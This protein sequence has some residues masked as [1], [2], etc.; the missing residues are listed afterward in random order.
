[1]LLPVGNHGGDGDC[2]A[3]QLAAEIEELSLGSTGGL[4]DRL[5][6]LPDDI[7]HSIL[8]RLPSTPAAARTCVLSRRWR[9]IWAQLPEIRFPFPSNPAVVG[10]ALA[11]S[12]AGP[13][14]RL[15]HVA[16]RDDTGAN[17]WLRTAASRL[18]AGGELYFYKRTPG[19]EK[20]QAEALS[21]QCRN[22]ELPCF[23]TAAKVWL[24]LGFVDLE[25]PPTGVFARLTELR[26]EHVNLERGFQLGDMVS[27]PRCPALRELCIARAWGVVSLCIISQ[28]LER[29]ELDILHGLEELTVVA[30]ML[31]ALNVHACFAWRKPVAAIYAS[32]LEVL[33]WSDAFDPS[34]VLFGEVEN[35]QQLTT[36]DIHVYGRFDYALL[37]DYVMLLQHF[38]TVSCLD[39]KLNYQRD[40]SQYEYLMGIITKLPN[41]KILSLWLH[42]KGH[43]IGPSVFHLLSKCPGIRELKLT[44]LDNLQVDT[45]CTSVCACG[46]QQNWSTSYTLDV[47]DEVEIRN[48]RGLEHDFAFVD[49]LFGVSTAI[50]KMTI[51]LHHLASPSEELFSLGNL[52]TCFEINYNT[53]EVSYAPPDSLFP[54][55]PDDCCE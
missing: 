45:P 16:C 17:A 7:L 38:P 15:L 40:L 6:A 36:F 21:W 28:T 9:G 22:F 54:K 13:A 30:P 48:F 12:A 42:T 19:E 43:A 47:L 35:L 32:R 23:E 24:R 11:A 3:V 18:I 31:R 53:S 5:S 33:W 46:Q 26:L 8:L 55:T 41:I 14:L 37:Q 20:G 1:M 2:G 34:F 44:L 29:L 50:K 25:L 52:G 10:P 39:L 4:G 51:T 27:S 49:M